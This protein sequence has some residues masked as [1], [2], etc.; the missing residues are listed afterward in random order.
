M[1][2]KTNAALTTTKTSDLGH[3]NM[4]DIDPKYTKLNELRTLP[5][6]RQQPRTSTNNNTHTTKRATCYQTHT[7]FNDTT[8]A[9]RNQ[10]A[11]K[12][13]L[14]S[15]NTTNGHTCNADLRRLRPLHSPWRRSTSTNYHWP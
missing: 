2:S 11:T 7:L 1:E 14:E 3:L 9:A 15:S 10:Q 6:A 8:V 13:D 4:D 12:R 5:L